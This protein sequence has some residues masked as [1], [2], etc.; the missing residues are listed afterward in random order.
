MLKRYLLHKKTLLL[1]GGIFLIVLLISLRQTGRR[2]MSA[3]APEPILNKA[4]VEVDKM[5]LSETEGGELEWNLKAE[6]AQVYEKKGIAYLQDITLEYLLTEG[7]EVVLTGDRGE[8]SLGQKNIFLQGNVGASSYHV[9]LK[10]DTLSWNRQKRMLL[11]EDPVWLKRE[12]VEITG[13][14]M[15]ADMSLKKIRLNKNVRTVVH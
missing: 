2:R 9:Q 13:R 3:P 7:E 4:D 14:G 6:R 11:T 15:V 8:I 1:L 5:E 10:T 12:N